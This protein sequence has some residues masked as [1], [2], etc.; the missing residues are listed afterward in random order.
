MRIL[1]SIDGSKVGTGPNYPVTNAKAPL[2]STGGIIVGDHGSQFTHTSPQHVSLFDDFIGI[3]GAAPSA[4]LWKFIEG[5]DSA[6]SAELLLDAPNG[7]LRMTTGDA[8]TGFAADAAQLTSSLSWQ[9]GNGGLCF[10]TRLKMSA[11]TTCTAFM[12]FTDLSAS[13][14]QSILFATGTTFTTNAT[15]ACGFLFDTTATSKKWWLT[16]VANDVDATMQDSG[17]APTADQYQTFRIEVSTT[18]TATFF[19]NGVAVGTPLTGALTAATDLTP[20]IYVSKLSV[21]ASMT[22]EIDYIHASMLRGLDGGNNA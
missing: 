2:I 12:G 10:Q 17:V 20:T 19:I 6:T 15:D 13:L 22:M 18:G 1:N 3:T 16:G 7:V 5:T 8:G 21:A 14:E 9:A 11:I 4:V